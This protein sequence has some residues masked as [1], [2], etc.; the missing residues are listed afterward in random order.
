LP[1]HPALRNAWPHLHE[2]ITAHRET[3]TTAPTPPRTEG[4]SDPGHTP[5]GGPDTVPGSLDP[6]GTRHF[7]DDAEAAR[8]GAQILDDPHRNP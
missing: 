4:A 7:A 5:A 2:Q 3:P 8:Y 6:N 1:L